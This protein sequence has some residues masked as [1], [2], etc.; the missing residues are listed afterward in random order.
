MFG[1]IKY[2]P[3]K[4]PLISVKKPLFQGSFWQNSAS[5]MIVIFSENM[6]TLTGIST[7]HH[8]RQMIWQQWKKSEHQNNWLN[9]NE[10]NFSSLDFPTFKEISFM[11]ALKHDI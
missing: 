8:Q 4:L 1:S 7:W 3:P 5:D 9:I 2:M 10:K 6:T 11:E